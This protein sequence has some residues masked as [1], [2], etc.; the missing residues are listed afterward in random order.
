MLN[1]TP[2]VQLH[3][4]KVNNQITLADALGEVIEQATDKTKPMVIFKVTEADPT[5]C[6]P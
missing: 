2:F 4:K 3:S 5:T 6:I 1:K